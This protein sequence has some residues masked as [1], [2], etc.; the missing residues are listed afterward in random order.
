VAELEGHNQVNSHSDRKKDEEP[1]NVT[2][3]AVPRI[4]I[5]KVASLAC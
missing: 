3:G 5:D 4:R 1:E 2:E